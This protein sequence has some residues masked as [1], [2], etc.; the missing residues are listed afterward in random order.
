MLG[1]TS[2]I[3]KNNYS[4]ITMKLVNPKIKKTQKYLK[5]MLLA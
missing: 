1:I 2:K 5:F 3:K 4:G